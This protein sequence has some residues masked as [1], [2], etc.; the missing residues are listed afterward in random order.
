MQYL[1]AGFLNLDTIEILGQIR[2]YCWG[3][4]VH[5]RVFATFL[6]SSHS[7]LVEHFSPSCDNQKCLKISPNVLGCDKIPV[8]GPLSYVIYWGFKRATT[9]TQYSAILLLITRLCKTLWAAE[10]AILGK[11]NSQRRLG[12]VEGTWEDIKS[13]FPWAKQCSPQLPG[14]VSETKKTKNLSAFT[15]FAIML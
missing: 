3:C 13:T 6:T 15:G 12:G 9:E 10:G 11:L 14:S 2:L 8:W 5:C 4:P 1:I 7:M